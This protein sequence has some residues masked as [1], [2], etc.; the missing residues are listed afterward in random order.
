[1]ESLNFTQDDLRQLAVSIAESQMVQYEEANPLVQFREGYQLL[2]V[3]ETNLMSAKRGGVDTS[4]Q[5]AR[6]ER[7]KTFDRK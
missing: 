7:L 2:H 3:A 6:L 4:E 1:M 5:I